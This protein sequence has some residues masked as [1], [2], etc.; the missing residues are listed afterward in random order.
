MN[1]SSTSK[2]SRVRF[3]GS[4]FELDDFAR[5]HPGGPGFIHLASGRD[6]TDLFASYHPHLSDS[7]I[8]TV[9]RKVKDESSY[10]EEKS[11]IKEIEYQSTANKVTQEH[12][13]GFRELQKEVL[14]ALGGFRKTKGTTAYFLKVFVLFVLYI[15]LESMQWIYGFSLYRAIIHGIVAALIGMNIMHEAVHHAASLNPKINHILGIVSG[16]MIGK[17]AICWRFSHNFLHH[18]YT[19]SEADP[20]ARTSPVLRAHPTDAPG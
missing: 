12:V 13:K 2:K 8:R 10:D 1:T 6:V 20:D 7:H 17:S 5:R 3:S 4:W 18:I 14:A 15:G 11:G 9:L 16:E 19:N